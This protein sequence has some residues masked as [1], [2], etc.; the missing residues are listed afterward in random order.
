MEVRRLSKEGYYLGIALA[1][2]RRSTCLRRHMGAI[3]VR[4]DSII[5]T[6]YNGSARGTPNCFEKGCMKSQLGLPHGSAYDSCRAGILHAEVNAI[7]NAARN[8]GGTNGATMFVAGGY[9]DGTKGLGAALCK[10]CQKAI[11]NAG[12]KRV[13]MAVEG[14]FKKFLVEDWV[15]EAK[16]T[17]T[18]DI[19]GLY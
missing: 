14:G 10:H 18:K 12:I 6:G 13:V 4:N 17:K 15:K 3:I 11:I 8:N 1:V 16:K 7:I 19:A 9:V 5:S 2:S